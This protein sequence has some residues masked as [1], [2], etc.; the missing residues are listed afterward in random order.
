MA[1]KGIRVENLT[2]VFQPNVVALD[3]VS[4]DVEKGEFL[5]VLGPSGS[6]K[7]TLLRIIA[8]LE[9]P[10]RG[11]VYIDGE[12][13]A[14]PS[15]KLYIPP[16]KRDVGMVFQNWAL[17]PN[18]RVFDNIAFPLEIKGLS[19]SEIRRRVKEVAEVLGI[20]ELLDRYPRQLS[21][22]QQQR[23][24]LARALVKNPKVLLLDEPFSN[25][26][27]RVRVT[28]RTFVK[29]VQRSLGITTVLVT[30][31]QADAFAVGDR[32]V[33]LNQGRIQQVGAPRELYDEPANLFTASFIGDPPMNIV[34]AHASGLEAIVSGKASIGEGYRIGVRPDEAI[35]SKTPPPGGLV[36]TGVVDLVESTGSREYAIVNIGRASLNVLVDPSSSLSPGERVYI[37]FR[38]VHIFNEKGERIATIVG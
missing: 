28:A 19:K 4:L 7:T 23:V 17:Y 16:Q 14:D 1:G 5:V 8:G 2:K 11:V 33:V 38:K 6:G 13:V 35:A 15:K 34:E 3:N 26:D 20:Q 25:L 21:G 37:V 10:T 12:A 22:G 32:I 9:R 31:D 36:A 30:H 18:M 27:A 29:K 24:A